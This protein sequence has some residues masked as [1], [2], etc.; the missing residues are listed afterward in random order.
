MKEKGLTKKEWKEWEK[1][2]KDNPPAEYEQSEKYK[3][4][5]YRKSRHVEMLAREFLKEKGKRHF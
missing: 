4:Y 2:V 5:A 1:K 3:D